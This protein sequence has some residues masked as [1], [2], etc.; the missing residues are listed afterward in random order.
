MKFRL[1]LRP[2]SGNTLKTGGTVSEPMEPPASPTPADEV[3]AATLVA[4]AAAN[5]LALLRVL[6]EPRIMTEIRLA[7]AESHDE[8]EAR[9]MARQAVR[10]H[11]TQ[12]VEAGIVVIRPTKREFGG[13]V[14]Y[15]LNHARLFAIAEDLRELAALR[16]RDPVPV[17]T[18]V[19]TQRASTMIAPPRLLLVKGIQEGRAWS[20]QAATPEETWVLGRSADVEI[21]LDYDPYVSSEH[22]RLRR[23]GESYS[24][25]ALRGSTNGT[26]LNQREIDRDREVGLSHGDVIGVG[27]SAFVF[28]DAPAASRSP[29]G[30]P[31]RSTHS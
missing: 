30:A 2:D 29:T 15:V 7:S 26:F 1:F 28:Q 19:G 12:L 18:T 8:G 17:A 9:A 24:I 23:R 21:V 6:R 14:E 22:C 3:L 13:T 31:A 16:P 20:L 11:I 25:E 27:R 4:I 5:R 10:K